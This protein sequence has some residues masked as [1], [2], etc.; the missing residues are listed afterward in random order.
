MRKSIFRNA[1]VAVLTL[2]AMLCQETWALAGTTG[3]I[4]GTVVDT[5]TRAP[6][7]D[8]QVTAVSPSQSATARTDASGHFTFL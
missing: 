7:A 6:I 3:G 4:S 1:F 2:L 5:E 8:A